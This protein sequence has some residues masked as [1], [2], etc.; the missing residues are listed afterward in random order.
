MEEEPKKRKRE[1][2]NLSSTMQSIREKEQRKQEKVIQ[3]GKREAESIPSFNAF[4]NKQKL[5][6][7]IKFRQSNRISDFDCHKIP[8][9]VK[10]SFPQ[11]SIYDTL[12]DL[13][14]KIQKTISEKQSHIKENLIAPSPKIKS[15]LLL[16]I[17][18]KHYNQ[19]NQFTLKHQVF[20]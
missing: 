20:P 8:D 12:K 7:L 14:T 10:L 6:R 17:Y 16:Q 1:L 3:L 19:D 4:L 15:Q 9:D 5:Q 11:C 13:E 18:N 2:K